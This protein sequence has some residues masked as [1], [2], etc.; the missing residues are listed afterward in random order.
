MTAAGDL[1][2]RLVAD[3]RDQLARRIKARDRARRIRAVDEL[4]F[5]AA[6]AHAFPHGT[7]R[8]PQVRSGP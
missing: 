2:S 4:E 8:L 6:R 5:T 1:T 3:R 7:P